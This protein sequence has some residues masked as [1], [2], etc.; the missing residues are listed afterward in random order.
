MRHC[1]ILSLSISCIC[2]GNNIVQAQ[3]FGTRNLRQPLQRQAGA[4]RFS[5][6]GTLQ[7]SERFLRGNRG[8][9]E[10]VG[11]DQRESQGFVGREQASRAATVAS[12]TAGIRARA[13][14]SSQIN[15]PLLPPE[16]GSMYHPR[17]R[18][19]FGPEETL[20]VAPV[21]SEIGGQAADIPRSSVRRD[22]A[23]RLT[24]ELRESSR[25]SERSR[26]EVWVA[27]RTATLRGEVVS[28]RERDLAELVVLVE[29]G[30]SRV[31]NELRRLE[32]VEPRRDAPR[33]GARE[34]A[35]SQLRLA[36][37]GD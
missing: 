35:S 22:V 37:S 5:Q 9:A 15:R 1:A 29:P 18:L 31:L 14:R 13:D 2:L 36:S 30:I 21:E 27:G 10:F 6:A 25:F 28:V 4:N 32:R 26:I 7:G 33:D 24:T 19:T 17:L 8:R 34:P 16:R 23:A 12:S 11:S 20:E 3:L